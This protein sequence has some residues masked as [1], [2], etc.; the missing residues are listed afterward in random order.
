MKTWADGTTK[1]NYNRREFV[2]GVSYFKFAGLAKKKHLTPKELASVFKGSFETNTRG[3]RSVWAN[4]SMEQYF[5]R[6]LR[7]KPNW[8]VAIPYTSVIR[9]FIMNTQLLR[10]DGKISF[11]PCGCGSYAGGGNWLAWDTC[12][13]PIEKGFAARRK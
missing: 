4:E 5:D 13:N 2:Y 6:V 12:R 7:G 8:E 9:F 11:C 10:D 3:S 1:V